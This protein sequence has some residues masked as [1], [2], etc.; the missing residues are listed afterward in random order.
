MK[1]ASARMRS[2]L[3]WTPPMRTTITSSIK[4][5]RSGRSPSQWKGS[6]PARPTLQGLGAARADRIEQPDVPVVSGLE[7][8]RGTAHTAAGAAVEQLVA[9]VARR[10]AAERDD[11]LRGAAG[12]AEDLELRGLA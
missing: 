9:G 7:V 5:S 6:V 8:A 4:L 2:E 3:W 11:R 10:P 12:L 1:S